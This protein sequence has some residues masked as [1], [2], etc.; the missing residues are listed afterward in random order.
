MSA[1]MLRGGLPAL[2]LIVAACS[3]GPIVT[4]AVEGGIPL[5]ASGTAFD[6][7]TLEVPAGRAISLVF[8]NRDG[9]PHNVSITQ[10]GA[11]LPLFVGEIFGGPAAR[12]YEVPALP[13]GRYAFR[14]DVHPEMTGTIVSG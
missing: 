14:C 3:A 13:A 6:R 8:E 5:V 10:A 11:A 12:V 4:P 9:A 1:G 7:T 2:A